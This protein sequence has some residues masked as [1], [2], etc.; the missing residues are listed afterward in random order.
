MNKMLVNILCRVFDVE[1]TPSNFYTEILNR[2]EVLTNDLKIKAASS[3]D[4]L[5]N[6]YAARCL[7]P[8]FELHIIFDVT[9]LYS[10]N[11]VERLENEISNILTE[12]SNRGLF[13]GTN[14]SVDDLKA[15]GI[16]ISPLMSTLL[17]AKKVVN[18]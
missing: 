1:E 16:D 15:A 17:V 3:E 14:I 10:Y 11:Q 5:T 7:A 18:K 4:Y 9:K 2:L 8:V 12:G 6:L 13:N